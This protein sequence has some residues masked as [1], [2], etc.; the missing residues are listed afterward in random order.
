MSESEVEV[1]VDPPAPDVVVVVE[2]PL[3]P[4]VVQVSDVGL[5]GPAGRD[6]RDG[7]DG[8]DG[9]DMS[10]LVAEHIESQT[11]HPVYDDGPSFLL[12][13]QNAKA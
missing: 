8:Q 13:Y 4:V 6:G 1:V 2:P 3:P 11:P 12:L 10:Y 5:P 9:S 7:I